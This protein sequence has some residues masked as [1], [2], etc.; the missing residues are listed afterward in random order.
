MVENSEVSACVRRILVFCRV[1]F[2][3]STCEGGYRCA[4]HFAPRIPGCGGV[5]DLAHKRAQLSGE[6]FEQLAKALL[7]HHTKAVPAEVA[8]RNEDMRKAHEAI[9]SIGTNAIPTLLQMLRATDPPLKIKLVALAQRQHLIKI[10]YTPAESLNAAAASGFHVLY[11]KGQTAV[12]ALIEI[13]KESRSPA[14]NAVQF[15]R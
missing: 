2:I 15:Q 5:A 11:S 13:A 12:P 10:R 6:N 7:P 8:S 1:H 4:V 3:L 14:P 9:R